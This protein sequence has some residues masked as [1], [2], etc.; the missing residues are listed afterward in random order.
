MELTKLLHFYLTLI[1]SKVHKR[2]KESWEHH[3]WPSCLNDILSRAKQ[4]F[5]YVFPTV[6]IFLYNDF[7]CPL[8]IWLV[9]FPLLKMS[10]P[11]FCYLQTEISITGI[12]AFI[13]KSPLIEG[14]H[15][16]TLWPLGFI[17][18]VFSMHQLYNSGLRFAH[19][20]S[21]CGTAT[22]HVQPLP[23]RNMD[24]QLSVKSISPRC[25]LFNVLLT[26]RKASF[27]SPHMK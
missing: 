9:R 13:S 16:L 2:E 1:V 23:S 19:L 15:L 17:D 5:L 22:L 24:K 4:N 10:F 21:F 6:E 25:K 8:I 7:M 12:Q 11:L 18:A 27:L 26:L 20:F 3:G 14:F